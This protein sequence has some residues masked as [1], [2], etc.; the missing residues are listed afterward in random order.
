MDW[1]RAVGTVGFRAYGLKFEF[2]GR[3]G[4]DVL[5]TNWAWLVVLLLCTN[6]NKNREDAVLAQHV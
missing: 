3:C 1:C 5:C 2:C 6:V 4:Q